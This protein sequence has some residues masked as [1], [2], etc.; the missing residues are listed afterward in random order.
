MSFS[1]RV[2]MAFLEEDNTQRAFFRLRPLLNSEGPCTQEEL[3]I[4]PDEGYARIVPDKNE[5]ANFKDRMRTLGRLCMIDLTPF[6]PEANKIRTNKNYSPEKGEMNQFILYSDVIHALPESLVYEVADAQSAQEIQE[7]AASLTTPLGYVRVGEQWY[8]PVGQG[9]EAV[10]ASEAA[11]DKHLHSLTM[12]DGKKRL[13]YWPAA[14]PS[15]SV[16]IAPEDMPLAAV[17][18]APM[19]SEPLP[20]A[21]DAPSAPA[22][23]FGRSQVAQLPVRAAAPEEDASLLGT[24]LY[25]GAVPRARL[26]RTRN[27]LHEVVDAQWRAAKY[28]APSAQLQQGANL[29]HVENPLEHFREAA[30]GAWAIPQAQQQVLDTLLALPGVQQRLEKMFHAGEPDSL[31]VSSMRRQLQ[32]LEAERLALLVQLDKARENKAAFR[33]EVLAAAQ[34]EHILRLKQLREEI[35]ACQEAEAALSAQLKELTDQRSALQAVCDEL[36]Q[37]D[38]PA[39]LQAFAKGC[40]LSQEKNPCPLR[41]SPVVAAKTPPA[42]MIAS[43]KE[44]FARE[45]GSLKQEDAVHFLTLFALCSRIQLAHPSLSEAVRFA[46]LCMDAL[47]LQSAF[48]VQTLADQSVIVESSCQTLSPV[49][50]ATPHVGQAEG[51]AS[52]KTLLL[53]KSP[54]AHLNHLAY[55]LSPWPIL[56]LPETA[57]GFLPAASP[58]VAEAPPAISIE[59]LKELAVPQCTVSEDELRWLND[60]KEALSAA[61]QPLPCAVTRVMTAYMATAGTWMQGGIAAAADYAF[62]AW[63]APLALQQDKLLQALKPLLPSLPRSAAILRH[64]L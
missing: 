19:T 25:A 33:E 13:F 23:V 1:D 55:D 34:Q 51:C 11:P 14:A 43:L 49:C 16:Q 47:G 4:L 53:S 8:G 52:L 41:L 12:P 5:Q 39:R 30:E 2:T 36:A 64:C 54:T 46:S 21:V 61:Q 9:R 15:V 7:V 28:E 59:S 6:P 56:I 18:M 3:S 35:A 10:P 44:A 22:S 40:H 17:Y 29:R 26:A 60:L 58:C 24:P 50:V 20:F 48:K 45:W 63:I 31:L 62:M 38:L 27:P 57:P 42:R 37:G 32:D